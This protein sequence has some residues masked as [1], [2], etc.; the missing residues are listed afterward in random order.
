[1]LE[2]ILHSI[3][4]AFHPDQCLLINPDQI[5]PNGF[6]SRMV[7]E[8]KDLW[9]G[10]EASIDRERILPGEERFVCPA[11]I[12]LPLSGQN[13]FGGI[14]YLG[15]SKPRDFS[16]EEVDFLLLLAKGIGG[17]LRNG[18]LH[19]EAEQTIAELTAL[20]HL[21]KEITSTLKLEDLFE[22]IIQSGLKM[23]GARGGVL[24]I[25]DRV[26]GELRVQFGIGDYD[27]DPLDEEMAKGVFFTQIP[28]SLN[29]P[30]Q[31]K[32]SSSV[33]C[34]PLLSKGRSFGTLAFYD[35]ETAG[36]RFNERDFQLLLTMANQ[37][38]CS[39]E[40]AMTH[41]E[42]SQLVQN[43]ERSVKQ[44]STLYE[45]NK[46]LLT[47]VHLERT[48]QMTLTAITIGEGFGFNR[49]MLFMVD[50][51]RRVLKGTLAVGP[52]NAEEAGRIWNALSQRRG[53]PSVVIPQL[54]PLPESSSHLDLI[55]RGIE[56]PLEQ[57]QCLLAKTVLEGKPFNIQPSRTEEDGFRTGCEGHCSLDSGVGCYEGRLLSRD[58][59]S[60]A[61]ATV[62]LWGKGRVIGVIL[63]D[64]LYNQNPIENEDLQF[65]TM[66]AHQ[67]GMAIEN[68][69][70]YRNLEEVHQELK[71]AQSLIGHQEKMAALGELS[72]TIAHEIKNPLTAIGGFARR[73]DRTMPTEST[74]KRYTQT[75]IRE[76]AR[77]ER[78]L[79]GINHYTHEAVTVHV[80][81]DLSR[82]LEDSLSLVQEEV[83]TGKIRLVREYAEGIPKVLGDHHQLKHA[84]YSLIKN[85]CESMDREGTLTLRL[86][87]FSKDGVSRIRL[88]VKDTGKGIDPGN[89][90]NIFNPFYSTK[91]SSFGLGL[92]M[93]HKIIVSHQ[94][95]IEIDNQPGKGATFIITFPAL[96][97][98]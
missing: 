73:L 35:R 2:Q 28:I 42:T 26:T 87:P 24:R 40:N 48:L 71:E 64:N 75:I 18:V 36:S 50:E 62:P 15:F 82:L 5:G 22:L 31:E 55:V 29:P 83:S 95:R 58:P 96:R 46:T 16:S 81:Q 77:L 91:E 88:E 49:A 90:S 27:Q 51:K 65:L 57:D 11:F 21:G 23:F 89:L 54:K 10:G 97:E 39:V 20:H 76:V 72:E 98:T 59:K 67:A 12:C 63:V 4:E 41:F 33:L 17:L 79:N 61:F 3:S 44:L 32:L 14:L 94:G 25:E 86:Y 80:P 60:Y 93:V 13:S 56:I 69:L 70:L 19:A 85:A 37:I 74:E 45:L 84:F 66:F 78:V 52:D 34:A 53:F 9:V 47:T 6:F 92:P 30:G 38:S 1:M 68:A 43:H 8:K 7:S